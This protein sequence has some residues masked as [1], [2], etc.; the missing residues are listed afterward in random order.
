MKHRPWLNSIRVQTSLMLLLSFGLVLSSSLFVIWFTLSKRFAALEARDTITHIE[1]VA[2][3]VANELGFFGKWITDWADWDDAVEYCK[4]GNPKFA[5]DNLTVGVLE[6][7]NISSVRY[8]RLDG[9]YVG[10]V[11]RQ[12]EYPYDDIKAILDHDI[13]NH[14]EILPK[15]EEMEGKSGIVTL[16]TSHFIFASRNVRSSNR[17]GASAGHIIFL[18]LIDQEFVRTISTLS[19]VSIIMKP[20]SSHM[21]NE[22]FENRQAPLPK[23]LSVAKA[24]YDMSDSEQAMARLWAYDSQDLP[25]LQLEFSLP[26]ELLEQGE[27]T[28]QYIVIGIAISLVL[29]LIVLNWGLQKILFQKLL[30][31]RSE[32]SK[33]AVQDATDRKVSVSSQTELRDLALKINEMLAEIQR[34]VEH[35]GQQAKQ[36][37][38][39]ELHQALLQEQETSEK[40]LRLESELRFHLAAMLAHRLNNPINFVQLGLSNTQQLIFALQAMLD[41]LLAAPAAQDPEAD[42]LYREFKKLFEQ[43]LEIYGTMAIGLKKSSDSVRE[44]RSLSGVD[45]ADLEL[46]N[47]PMLSSILEELIATLQMSTGKDRLGSA[48]S[49]LDDFTFHGNQSLLKNALGLLLTTS[50]QN[51]SG[52]LACSLAKDAQRRWFLC[53]EAD[54]HWNPIARLA[55]ERCINHILQRCHGYVELTVLPQRMEAQVIFEAC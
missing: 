55:L 25:A 31:L 23:L 43:I 33:L 38:Q 8:Y 34:R 3:I 45:G 18:R 2:E 42:A 6:S 51:S 37:H 32:V 19:K 28:M 52:T 27:Q 15:P 10:G 48:T 54:F 44:I 53:I 11:E 14:P 36:I 39:L 29:A 49:Q 13:P 16:G 30:R 17:D 4:T 46:L 21:E 9:T 12:P 20:A 7:L 26:R 5:Q 50:L 47:S 41:Q 24:S 35:E 1:R 22:S 40:A